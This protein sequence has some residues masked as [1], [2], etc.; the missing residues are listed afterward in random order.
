MP[1]SAGA[2]SCSALHMHLAM[3]R[4]LLLLTLVCLL[5]ICCC[6]CCFFALVLLLLL[7][8]W[9]HIDAITSCASPKPALS[10]VLKVRR[11]C[12]YPGLT[13]TW[14]LQ[15]ITMRCSCGGLMGLASYS[16]KMLSK[17]CIMHVCMLW[18]MAAELCCAVT[19]SLLPAC[20]TEQL[21]QNVAPNNCTSAWTA[22]ALPLADHR[23]PITQR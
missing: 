5:L 6:C 2:P 13:A 18:L 1:C 21:H 20:Y 4:L 3:S 22:C 16:G 12:F 11:C 9:Q 8:V 19:V 23:S 14:C 10:R 17:I 7:L 15:R